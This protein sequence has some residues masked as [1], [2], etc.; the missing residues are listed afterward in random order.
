MKY[1]IAIVGL[2]LFTLG[3]VLASKA[4]DL[5]CGCR[6]PPQI[7]PL[8]ETDPCYECTISSKYQNAVL[9]FQIM[10]IGSIFI[11]LYGFFSEFEYGKSK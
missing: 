10:M 8:I 6:A 4:Y 5:V 3:F 11:V 1:Q 2:L 7:M 9:F